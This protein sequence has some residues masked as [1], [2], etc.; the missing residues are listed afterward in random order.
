[1]LGPGDSEKVDP[2][3]LFDYKAF[4]CGLIPRKLRPAI[5]DFQREA[6][7][8]EMKPMS[9]GDVCINPSHFR[10]SSIWLVL[11]RNFEFLL[12]DPILV[13]IPIVHMGILFENCQKLPYTCIQYS[14]T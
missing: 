1:M 13:P 10:F 9:G 3:L 4:F 14:M 5:Y 12:E 6:D 11:R 2:N 8:M 7:A